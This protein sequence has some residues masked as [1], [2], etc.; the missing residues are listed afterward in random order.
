MEAT[1]GVD[2]VCSSMAQN[3]I[4]A[5]ACSCR[6]PVMWAGPSVLR[7]GPGGRSWWTPSRPQQTHPLTSERH[8]R[9]PSSLWLLRPN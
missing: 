6:F 8:H 9:Y 7:I 1:D 4:V 3:Q 2:L 5:S